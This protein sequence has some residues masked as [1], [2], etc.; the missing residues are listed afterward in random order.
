[1]DISKIFKSK[2]R[3]ALLRLYF[4]NPDNEYY[5]RE[6][7]RLLDIPVSM[8]RKEL[9]HLES[10]EMFS[11]RKRG[12]LT[13]YFLNKFYPLYDEMKSIVFKTI[14]V[15][16]I[17]KQALEKIDG[18]EKA[19]IFGSFAKGNEGKASDIDLLVVGSID[20]D[21][22]VREIRTV[23][24]LVKREI[25]YTLY[26]KREFEER[27]L[28]KDSFIMDIMKN[29]KIILIGDNNDDRKIHS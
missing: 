9:L 1:M 16:G 11:S 10:A 7:E 23:E 6:L 15:N 5:L 21:K 22:L 26:S 29:P 24:Q 13:F 18:V 2:T 8:I 25:N 17:L 3:K 28:K 27:N 12:N 19:F 14:G 4:S 20:E